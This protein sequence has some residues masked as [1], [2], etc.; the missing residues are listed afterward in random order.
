MDECFICC[1]FDGKSSSEKTNEICF[2]RTFLP[3]PLVKLSQV[4]NCNCKSL[5]AHNKCLLGI[6]KCPTCRK[7]SEKPNLYVRTF[8]DNIFGWM[9]KY[10]KLNPHMIKIIKNCGGIFVIVLL[11]LYFLIHNNIIQIN[12]NLIT[13]VSIGILIL[14]QFIGGFCLIM[15]DYFIKYWLYDPKTNKIMSLE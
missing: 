2:N 4:Y 10:I 1:S 12:S 7:Y 11:C 9:F 3:Y 13:N 15:E 14:V 6:K 5:I 8:Y